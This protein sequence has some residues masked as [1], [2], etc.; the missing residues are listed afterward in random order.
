MSKSAFNSTPKNEL[1][2]KACREIIEELMSL[3]NIRELKNINKIKIK[4]IKK[5]DDV[6]IPKNSHLLSFLETDEERNKLINILRIKKVRTM[7]GVAVVAIMSEPYSCPHGRCLYCPGGPESFFDSPQSYTGFEPAT[8]RGIQNNFDP[9]LQVTNRLT[10]LKSIGHNVSKIEL[11][12]MGGTFPARDM[13]YQTKFIKKSF[14]AIADFGSKNKTPIPNETLEEVI[15]RCE[16]SKNRLVGFTIETRPDYCNKKQINF[17]LNS[18]VTRVELGV[19]TIYNHIYKKIER[20]HTIEEVIE[21]TRMLK[22]SGLKVLYHIMPNLPETTID[23]DFETFKTIYTDPRFKP[24]MLKIYPCLVVKDTKLYDLWKKELYKPY[25]LD[26]T[27]NLLAKA[28]SII[29]KWIRIQRVQRDIPVQ[30]IEAGVQ[31]SN[32]RQ[33][34]H[35]R[36][37]SLN[38]KCNC[39]RCREVG[40]IK[41]K[42]NRVPE[43]DNIKLNLSIYKASQGEEIFL[44]YE[45]EIK[46]ILIGYLRLRIPSEK[47][48][49]EEIIEKPSSIVRALHVYGPVVPIGKEKLHKQLHWQHKNIGFK[50]LKKAEEI[51]KNE[52]DRNKILVISGIGVREYYR[53][54]GYKKDGSYVSKYL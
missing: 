24:D 23:M 2:K 49:R 40:L 45:D 38:L 9:Y 16:R 35:K 30:Y 52:Y 27:I 41:L 36:M 34:V 19:Q 48:F 42:E 37:E 17:S 31:K 39:I 7:S 21:T 10:Q 1:F 28:Q 50:L 26:E 6:P 33:L 25:S 14:Q 15:L 47:A 44:S 12:I 11:I 4:V 46:D 29:P 8:R 13:E 22:D 43:P 5:Y 53:K 54:F 18:G 3:D 51:S 32:L 20:G